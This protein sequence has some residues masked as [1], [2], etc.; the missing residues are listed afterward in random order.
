MEDLVVL[1]VEICSKVPFVA[2]HVS[3][4]SLIEHFLKNEINSILTEAV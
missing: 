2:P 3:S 1:T 4:F